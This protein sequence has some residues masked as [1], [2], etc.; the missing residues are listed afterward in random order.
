MYPR[1]GFRNC[2]LMTS[3][4]SSVPHALPQFLGSKFQMSY[5]LSLNISSCR[6]ERSRLCLGDFCLFLAA[7]RSLGI[8][9]SQMRTE[10][11]PLQWKLRVLNTG[12]PGCLLLSLVWLFATSWTVAH[13]SPLS[14]GILQARILEWVAVPSL[15][16]LPNP[17]IKPRPPAFQTNSSLSEPP[18]KPFSPVC[19]FNDGYL[20]T[21]LLNYLFSVGMLLSFFLLSIAHLWKYL[22]L[23]AHMQNFL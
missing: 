7:P 8:L 12:P 6:S 1:P 22:S 9:V 5:H 4:V 15:R 11:G 13:Q 20:R 19:Y 3:S 21:Y 23:P 10:P 17:G 16:D 18:G 14:M 2:H